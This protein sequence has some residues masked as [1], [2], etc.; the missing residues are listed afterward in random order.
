MTK[1]ITVTSLNDYSRQLLIP[2]GTCCCCAT[3]S[4]IS[5]YAIRATVPKKYLLQ[6]SGVVKY[7]KCYQWL[8]TSCSTSDVLQNLGRLTDF[9]WCISLKSVNEDLATTITAALNRQVSI[10]HTGQANVQLGQA[11]T[12]W[13]EDLF[14]KTLYQAS[15]FDSSQP[16]LIIN[17]FWL[18]C[19][20][21]KELT[22]GSMS[23]MNCCVVNSTPAQSPLGFISER[24]L[25]F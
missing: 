5:S 25:N 3:S 4:T 19:I 6:V 21:S 24:L 10:C 1:L 7:H 23:S 9:I 2:H 13:L 17:S 8:K 16:N 12:E 20:S 11:G 22:M 14:T 18:S 15:A